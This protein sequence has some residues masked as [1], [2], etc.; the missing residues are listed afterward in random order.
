MHF[1]PHLI[2][3][4][5]A[6]VKAAGGARE[7]RVVDMNNDGIKDIVIASKRGLFVFMGNKS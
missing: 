4:D 2:D 1:E 5:T 6:T 7:F 3:V